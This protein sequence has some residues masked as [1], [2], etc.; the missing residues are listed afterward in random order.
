[1][2]RSEARPIGDQEVSRAVYCYPLRIVQHSRRRRTAVPAVSTQWEAE[3]IAIGVIYNRGDHVRGG[4][5]TA[6]AV[7]AIIQDENVPRAV[8][9]NTNRQ[10]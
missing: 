4:V 8:K 1:M 9:R 5:Y 3:R 6:N 2:D 10:I 7:V